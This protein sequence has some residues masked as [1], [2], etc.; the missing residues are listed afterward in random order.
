MKTELMGVPTPINKKD[1]KDVLNDNKEISTSE[2]KTTEFQRSF[3]IL[4]MWNLHKRSRT[5]TMM[6]RRLY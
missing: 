5:G 2:E 4:D 1:G 3:G 6:R